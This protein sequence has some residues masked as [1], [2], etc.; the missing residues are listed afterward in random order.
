[1][2]VLDIAFKDM[3]LYFRSSFAVGMMVVV[4]LIITGL[5]YAAFGGV[6]TSSE[7]ENYSLPVI[8]VQVV[9]HDQGDSK[10]GYNAGQ[11]LIDA[12]TSESVQDVFQVTLSDEEAAAFAAVDR[13]EAALALVIPVNFTQAV[14]SGEQKA[15]LVLYQD[16]AL[17]F[18][19]GITRG[20]LDQLVNGLAGGQI[21]G[22]T[23]HEQFAAHGLE[24]QSETRTQIE[25]SYSTW[26]TGLADG[27][28]LAIPLTIRVPNNPEEKSVTD[29]RN[30]LM[31]PVMAG[32]MIFF[33]FFTGANSAQSIIKEQEEG[34]LARIFTTPTPLTSILGGK[35][36]A[37]FFILIV[38]S[39][40]LL[41]AS[42]L[43]F[44]IDWGD[45]AALSLVIFGL[46]VSAS[47]F[48][49]WLLSMIKTTRQAGPVIAAV[50]T[51]TGMAGGLMTTG[52]Q[53][54]PAAM[55]TAGLLVP[56]GWAL[57]GLK[58]VLFGAGPQDVIV[59][60]LVLIAFGTIF[61]ALG[62]R[63]FGKRFA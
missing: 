55:N 16:P 47:G 33:V 42:A 9:N 31:G 59:P 22:R 61:F 2:K 26:L 37:V 18:G 40:V 21:A 34:T 1:M 3:L 48:G 30:S 27:K 49:I 19:P 6:L 53:G 12:L 35:F 51:L 32:M 17:T 20:I 11:F 39:I 54:V 43:I 4:P 46:V 50:L 56:Q 52:L 36:T 8:K 60:V 7:T 13:Q 57:R 15:A 14:L 23:A 45:P 25:V 29:H 5:I 38:Q 10:T 24:L 62:A 63:S 41:I 28:G 58:L 44:G